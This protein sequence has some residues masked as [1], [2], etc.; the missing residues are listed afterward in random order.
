MKYYRRLKRKLKILILGQKKFKKQ[1]KN[2]IFESNNSSFNYDKIEL[3][4]NVV[5]ATKAHFS[6]E[7]KIGNNAMLGPMM[8]I[9]GG[10]HI[11]G[12]LGKSVR[13]LKPKNNENNQPVLIEDE[14]W[15]GANVTILKGVVLGM[16]SV[17]GAGSVI[18]KSIPP[19]TVAV[20]NPATSIKLIFSD[21]DLEEHLRL[22][23]YDMQFSSGVVQRR[24]N[25]LE[26]RGLMNLE[27]YRNYQPEEK[28]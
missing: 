22:L 15:C 24:K 17:I 23:G 19:Y 25:E 28:Q 8:T 13:F 11:F 26:K 16:G 1:G 20:G 12:V 21:S 6:G 10:D 7:I 4:D 14:V 2:P 9:M 3:G 27:I 18:T 5:I